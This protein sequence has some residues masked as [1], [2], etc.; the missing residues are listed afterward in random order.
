MLLERGDG[1]LDSILV[2]PLR[3]WEYAWSKVLTLTAFA[4]LESAIIL[5]IAFGPGDFNVPALVGGILAMCVF[6]TFAG[7]A[8]VAPHRTVTDFLVPGAMIVTLVFELPLL[9]FLG[10]WDVPATY[11]VPTAPS[12]S[13]MAGAFA[14]I[15][16]WE[17]IYGVSYS[18][19][20]IVIAAVLA[21][22][23]FAKHIV[24]RGA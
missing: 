20:W 1:T 5:L 14:P 13:L 9:Q 10:A 11:L 18:A 15:P 22:R 2:T 3:F 6:N 19:L 7:M 8:Q 21:R 23:R 12:L 4:L 24:M 17:W 16:R